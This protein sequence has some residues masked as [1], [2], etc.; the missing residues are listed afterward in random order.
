MYLQ[1]VAFT[2]LFVL[3]IFILNSYKFI[4]SCKSRSISFTQYLTVVTFYITV[5][6]YQN[7]ETDI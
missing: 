2:S 4:G 3:L 1:R 7:Q 6:E 5:V